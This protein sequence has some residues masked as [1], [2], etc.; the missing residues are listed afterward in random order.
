MVNIDKHTTYISKR[1]FAV[2]PSV[3][4]VKGAETNRSENRCIRVFVDIGEKSVAEGFHWE[5]SHNMMITAINN[6]EA[7]NTPSTE[8][9]AGRI[10]TSVC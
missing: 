2:L 1:S 3:E 9:D 7:L 8:D 5:S 6:R 4:R 10:K